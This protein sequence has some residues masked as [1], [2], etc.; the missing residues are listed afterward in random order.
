MK[1]SVEMKKCTLRLGWMFE[2]TIKPCM[3]LP[4]RVICDNGLNFI[5]N[6]GIDD[7]TRFQNVLVDSQNGPETTES[8]SEDCF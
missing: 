7:G 2:K 8:M 1:T 6:R 5:E 3:P 4:R